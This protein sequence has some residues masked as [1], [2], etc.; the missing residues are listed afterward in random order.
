MQIDK[1]KQLAL[2]NDALKMLDLK[3]CSLN[4]QYGSRTFLFIDV[5]SSSHPV[6]CVDKKGYE[7]AFYDKDF[8]FKLQ[9]LKSLGSMHSF[10]VW[11]GI[12]QQ[13]LFYDVK[14]TLGEPLFMF[15]NP[16]YGCKSLEEIAIA[17]DLRQN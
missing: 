7:F 1:D 11:N 4:G 15:E 12:M 6:T 13:Y 14:S 9:F 16:F 5:H 10:I 8:N 2:F 3:H 17:I